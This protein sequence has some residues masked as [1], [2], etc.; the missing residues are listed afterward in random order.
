MEPTQLDTYLE[1]KAVIGYNSQIDALYLNKG[2]KTD[3][4]INV[5]PEA[6]QT[7]NG[8]IYGIIKGVTKIDDSTSHVQF[9]NNSNVFSVSNTSA[10]GKRVSSVLNSYVRVEIINGTITSI[11]KVTPETDKVKITQ[12]YTNQLL[13]DSITYMEYSTDIKVYVCTLDKSGN[14]TSFKSGAKGDI[15]SG[16]IV[17][18]Y[19]LYGGFDG[20]IDVV[21]IYQ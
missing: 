19:D 14:V 6:P 9:F 4:I 17:Q 12:V 15:K 8:T 16:S 21:M 18:L 2:I 20:I 3:N 1:G 10:A 7:Y 13:I 5:T 11:E